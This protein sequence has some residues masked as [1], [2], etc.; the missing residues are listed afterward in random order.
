MNRDKTHPV[1]LFVGELSESHSNNVVFGWMVWGREPRSNAFRCSGHS[2]PVDYSMHVIGCWRLEL[3][4]PLG[5][6]H[7]VFEGKEV[8]N[9]ATLTQRAS[10]GRIIAMCEA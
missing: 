3:S 8:I 1:N 2:R 7:Q 9:G 10:F 5:P 6:E 4:R